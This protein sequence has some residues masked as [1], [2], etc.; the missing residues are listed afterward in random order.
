MNA[1]LEIHRKFSIL[2]WAPRVHIWIDGREVVAI[3]NGKNGQYGS[4]SRNTRDSNEIG[5]PKK[6]WDSRRYR[7]RRRA[8]CEEGLSPAFT[9]FQTFPD[10]LTRENLS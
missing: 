7:N 3:A 9:A 1:K 6:Q 4:P 2:G 5:K 8:N 10:P